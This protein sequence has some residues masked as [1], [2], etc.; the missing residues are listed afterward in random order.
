MKSSQRRSFIGLTV[1]IVVVLGSL[2]NFVPV[3]CAQIAPLERPTVS[4]LQRGFKDPPDDA[5][6][7]MRWWW[8]GPAVTKAEIER[9]L[10]MM[11]EGGIGGFEIQ[12]TYPLSPDDETAGIKNSPYLSD[13][14]I[15]ALRFTAEKAH[16][17]GLRMDLT[18]GSG[19]PYGGP[20]VPVNQ[21]AGR[22][23]Y[24]HVKVNA[25]SGRVKIPYLANGEKLTG[26]FL[27][28]PSDQGFVPES[29]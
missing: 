16:E 4:D 23:R 11:K 29:L 1:T 3:T 27:A 6:I 20:Q 19:W 17:L 15:E 13:E 26:V 25:N 14:F 22:L 2:I 21:A 5:R 9:E 10:R 18:L 7:M 24:E 8:Y 28:N 12:A